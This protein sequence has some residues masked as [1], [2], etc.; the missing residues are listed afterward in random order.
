MTPGI[1]SGWVT[2]KEGAFT[3]VLSFWIP[4]KGIKSRLEFIMLRRSKNN[5]Q[6]ENLKVFP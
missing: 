1:E 5:G 6:A 3:P 2:G 4:V